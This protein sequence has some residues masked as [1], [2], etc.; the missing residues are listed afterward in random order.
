MVSLYLI[1]TLES[2]LHS[3]SLASKKLGI[4]YEKYFEDTS[5]AIGEHFSKKKQK[6]PFYQYRRI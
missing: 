2:Q 1:H 4:E 6:T 3:L 5:K